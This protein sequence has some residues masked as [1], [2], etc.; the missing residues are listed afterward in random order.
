MTG[1]RVTRA[2]M[3]R[4]RRQELGA[5]SIVVVLLMTVLLISAALVV[6][7]GAVQARKAQL[8][9]A[10][11]AA[12][13]AIAQECFEAPASSLAGCAASVISAAESTAAGLA[14]ANLN[15]GEV[16]VTSVEFPTAA[17]VRVTLAST[18]QGYFGRIV[19]VDSSDLEAA[20]TAEWNPPAVPLALAM[21]S[22]A[23]PDPGE[24]TVVQSSIA[25]SALL[26][27]F[28]GEECGLF[29]SGD[30]LSN[31]TGTIGIVAGGWLTSADP[32]LGLTAGDCEYDP[33]LLTT[34][35]ATVS[36]VAPT[37]CAQAVESWGASPSSPQRVLLPVFDDGLNQLVEDDVLGM[38]A[39]DR[40]AVVDVTGYS[41]T[42][43]LGLG[44]VDGSDPGL[45][46]SDDGV[47]GAMLALIPALLQGLLN[48]VTGCQALEGT[49]VGFATADEAAAM[50]SGVR[51]ID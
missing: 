14:V 8:Q 35:S 39:V 34:A 25:V 18:Q 11:D 38:G 19:D 28:L 37:E 23:F 2:G 26:E 17:T 49:F 10:A 40:Y 48:T 24:P 44:S 42:G 27:P 45:C 4:V 5:T 22:C 31:T 15:D 33:N 29:S 50:T 36:K 13:V 3:P 41:F 9:D 32:I 1:A 16:T 7:I 6:D 20:A 51:L 43:V 46:T 21:A 30:L 47:I 12:A